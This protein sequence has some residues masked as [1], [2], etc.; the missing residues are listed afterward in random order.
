MRARMT[1]SGFDHRR[2]QLIGNIDDALSLS[3]NLSLALARPV[4]ADSLHSYVEPNTVK[5]ANFSLN[6]INTM[7][8]FKSNPGS[9]GQFCGK[10]FLI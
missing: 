3:L 8:S 10:T 7:L 4:H 5:T 2:R 6:C 9:P 1:E